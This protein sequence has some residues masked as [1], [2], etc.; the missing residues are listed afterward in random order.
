MRLV[1]TGSLGDKYLDF[2]LF[3]LY[4]PVTDW[5]GLDRGPHWMLAWSGWGRTK[6]WV[7]GFRCGCCGGRIRPGG[8]CIATACECGEQTGPGYVRRFK[9]IRGWS[10]HE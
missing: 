5:A 1:T 4:P 10:L 8:L 7:W 2:R 9:V 3:R 6:S